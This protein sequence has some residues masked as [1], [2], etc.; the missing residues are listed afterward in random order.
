MGDEKK[1][2]LDRFFSSQGLLSRKEASKWIRTGRIMVNGRAVKDPGAYVAPGEDTIQKDGETL[3]YQ[4]YRYLMMNKPEGVVS[5][6]RDGGGQT[7]LDLL[8]EAFRRPGL[9]P[10][11]RLDKNATGLLI[12]TD[13]GEYAHRMLSPRQHVYKQYQVCL[14]RPVTTADRERFREGIVYQGISYASGLLRQG[15]DNTGEVW[16]REGKYHQVKRMFEACGNHVNALKR[17]RIGGLH[18]DGDLAPA[19]VR[20]MSREEAD[21]VFE[22]ND[23]DGFQ[24]EIRQGREN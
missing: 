22:E 1:M 8:P 2:R 6:T 13:D 5:A 19:A 7:V 9:F 10:A 11:G 3:F 16:I 20:E 15:P 4:K 21:L 23:T 18:L 12:I 24:R 14:D 17:I